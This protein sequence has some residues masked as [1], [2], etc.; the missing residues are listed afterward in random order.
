M[1]DLSIKNQCYLL[2]GGHVMSKFMD[3]TINAN[4]AF[5]REEE[6]SMRGISGVKQLLV[7]AGNK[8]GVGKTTITV[9]LAK[10]LVE[11]GYQVGI[12][13]TTGSAELML[14]LSTFSESTSQKPP[15]R[16]EISIISFY[17]LKG[18]RIKPPKSTA[19]L[20]EMLLDSF[21]QTAWGT[22]DFLLLDLP[23][24]EMELALYLGKILPEAK[25]LL[26]TTPS[27]L[28][29]HE[30]NKDIQLLKNHQITPLGL[31]ENMSY[32]VSD[33]PQD[34]LELVGIFSAGGGQRISQE[35]GIPLLTTIPLNTDIATATEAERTVSEYHPGSDAASFFQELAE[36]ILQCC[37]SSGE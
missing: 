2:Y 26:A 15:Q 7:L 20:K 13:D 17:N 18:P 22:L 12:I 14:E 16:S 23:S 27:T 8:G 1:R 28:A 24:G 30:L 29:I 32:F 6:V 5:Q 9:N 37:G 21:D 19:E 3:R 10:A 25:F 34:P 35:T 33:L 31:I 4:Q 11:Q 36:K